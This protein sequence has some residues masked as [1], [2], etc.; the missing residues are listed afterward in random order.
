MFETRKEQDF[1]RQGSLKSLIEF[2][3]CGNVK[4]I[5]VREKSKYRQESEEA[6]RQ[7]YYLLIEDSYGW[8]CS[9]FRQ[10]LTLEKAQAIASKIPYGRSIFI[11]G[12]VAVRKGNTY[13]NAT[14]FKNPDD[15]D[16]LLV[17]LQEEDDPLAGNDGF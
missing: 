3:F 1:T 15:T 12:E 6:D 10:G 5:S 17:S 2:E 8:Q 16:I 4:G 14:V 9:Y 11:R 13:F 7:E